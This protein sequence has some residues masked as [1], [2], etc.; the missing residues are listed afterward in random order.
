MSKLA[1]LRGNK[2]APTQAFST[3]V[4]KSIN[5]VFARMQGL[6][7]ANQPSKYPEKKKYVP[8]RFRC[9]KNETKRIVVLD[10]KFTF[11]M[12]EHSFQNWNE[13]GRWTTERCISEWDICPLCSKDNVNTYDIILV[14]VL[15]LTPWTT[16]EGTTVEYTKRVLGL[17]KN[18]LAAFQGLMGV[19]GSLRGLVLD[20]TR[21]NGEKESASG[22][23]TYVS[24]LSE[25]DMLSEF[26]HEARLSDKGTVIVPANDSVNVWNY[27]KYFGVPSKSEL[28]RKYGL[29]A[30]PGSV[31]ESVTNEEQAINLMELNEELPEVL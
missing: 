21:G 16:K 29:P 20:M 12:R 6:K 27:D 26:G 2:A 25:E 9:E 23:P 19:H 31:E 22:K 14:T 24:T 30:I 10:E 15:D 7:T 13:N 5:D 17:K 28:I 8:S 4:D 1:S 11:G 18:D 3:E